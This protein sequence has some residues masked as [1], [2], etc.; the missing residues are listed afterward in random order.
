MQ[1]TPIIRFLGDIEAAKT[2]I[3][4]GL[5]LG[6]W[7]RQ[8][9]SFQGLKIHQDRRVFADGT[10][11]LATIV[12]GIETIFI[13][14][15]VPVMQ[16]VP[17]PKPKVALK[18]MLQHVVVTCGSDTIVWCV[19]L[20]D[21]TEID[22]IDWSSGPVSSSNEYLVTWKLDHAELEEGDD[23]WEYE[24]LT[25]DQDFSGW[26]F[27]SPPCEGTQYTTEPPVPCLPCIYAPD[28]YHTVTVSNYCSMPTGCFV[29][30]NHVFDDTF[31][32]IEYC[33]LSP[34]G[35]G[36]EE[37]TGANDRPAV[38]HQT[39]NYRTARAFNLIN[40]YN[41]ENGYYCTY[42]TYS[43]YS[44]RTGC[45]P[46][47]GEIVEQSERWSFG[48][49]SHLGSIYARG[50][51]GEM[52]SDYYNKNAMHY[53]TQGMVKKD[54]VH[55]KKQAVVQIFGT[56][57]PDFSIRVITAAAS[58]ENEDNFY[59]DRMVKND[60]FSDAIKLLADE[61]ALNNNAMSLTFHKTYNYEDKGQQITAEEV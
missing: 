42:S 52:P 46:G 8:F 9:M 5:N 58:L 48:Q 29:G 16:A 49:K 7:V 57:V 1:P 3:H 30:G 2:K 60:D 38:Q 36:T 43:Y 41:G 19:D 61:N 23:P 10:E 24:A 15:P 25:L 27:P 4:L 18:Y 34:E 55:N 56:R 6:R 54:N 39:N 53:F 50:G 45:D 14:C 51:L 28:M 40:N 33:C 22:G 47:L 13:Y 44:Y 35:R 20:N 26:A 32:D 11:I 12:H 21:Y 37:S 59:P 31:I 17:V